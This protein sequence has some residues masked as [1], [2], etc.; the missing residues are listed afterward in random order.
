MQSLQERPVAQVPEQARGTSQWL[1]G[2]LSLRAANSAPSS[3]PSE[4]DP[5][6]EEAQAYLAKCGRMG[7]VAGF[8]ANI[9]F[10]Y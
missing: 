7:R 9:F 2:G 8:D 3:L 4:L 6:H 1:G 10:L 5:L